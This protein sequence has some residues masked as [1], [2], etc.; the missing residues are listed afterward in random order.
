MRVRGFLAS[1]RRRRR[2]FR[3]GILLACGLA[4]GLLISF[5]GNTA[6]QDKAATE[7]SKTP[8]TVYPDVKQE[9]L[10]KSDYF[11]ARDVAFAFI[12]TAVERKHLERSCGLVSRNMREGMTCRQWESGTIPVVPYPVDETLTKYAFDFSFPNSI[13]MK[14]ALFPTAG[15]QLKPSVFRLDLVRAGPHKWLVDDWQPAGVPPQLSDGA[16]AAPSGPDNSIG[17]VW[18]LVPV[19]IFGLLVVFPIGLGAR[20]W[21]RARRADRRHPADPLPPLGR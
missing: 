3:L 9:R 1:P 19:G 18:L 13:G 21:W 10:P 12:R 8:P 20:G 6:R 4:L 5:G 14:F 16:S 7:F 2:L 17:A 15:S 11:A